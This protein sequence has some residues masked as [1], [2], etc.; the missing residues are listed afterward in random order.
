MVAIIST[1]FIMILY[2]LSHKMIFTVLDVIWLLTQGFKLLSF[3]TFIL[4]FFLIFAFITDILFRFLFPF[5]V[6]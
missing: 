5:C 1:I 6:H 2:A 4:A 3:F